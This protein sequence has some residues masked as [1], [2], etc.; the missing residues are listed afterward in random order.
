MGLELELA[1]PQPPRDLSAIST[2]LAWKTTTQWNVAQ[3]TIIR[4]RTNRAEWYLHRHRSTKI[5]RIPI[6]IQ[7]NNFSDDTRRTKDADD[8]W[9]KPPWSFPSSESEVDRRQ[10]RLFPA[11]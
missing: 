9:N 8:N 3:K 2:V 4:P 5:S 10:D 1:S 6:N 7:D 11:T